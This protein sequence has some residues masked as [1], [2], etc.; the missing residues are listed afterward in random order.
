MEEQEKH[1]LEESKEKWLEEIK[2]DLPFPNSIPT[3]NSLFIHRDKGLLD[4]SWI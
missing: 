2:V 1:W 3:G 4:H